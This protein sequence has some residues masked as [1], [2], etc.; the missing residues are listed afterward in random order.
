[1]E[2]KLG[3][4][5]CLQAALKKTVETFGGIDILCN[6]AGILDENEWEK[7]VSINMVALY[8]VTSFRSHYQYLLL[9]ILIIH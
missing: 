8:F 9:R 5:F 3:V 2:L 1:M 4:V 6:N 7:M